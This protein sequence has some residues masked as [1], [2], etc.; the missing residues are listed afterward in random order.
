MIVKK[1]IET[2]LVSLIKRI[3]TD[4]FVVKERLKPIARV[5]LS[6]NGITIWRSI[7]SPKV[8][9]FIKNKKR[10]KSN[11]WSAIEIRK[12]KKSIYN[13]DFNVVDYT[14]PHS[15]VSEKIIVDL[16]SVIKSPHKYLHRGLFNPSIW[17]IKF[18]IEKI[19]VLNTSIDIR[20]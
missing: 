9:L 2:N 8:L 4:S 18:K 3:I 1:H 11:I 16:S 19:N 12:N 17:F 15:F 6:N 13:V 5:L 20:D 10:A 14:I 7:F